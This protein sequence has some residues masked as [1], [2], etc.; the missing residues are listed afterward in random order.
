M[1]AHGGEGR[2]TESCSKSKSHMVGSVFKLFFPNYMY[3]TMHLISLHALRN[4]WVEKNNTHD[5]WDR[6]ILKQ[7]A[8][9]PDFMVVWHI[10][11]IFYGIYTKYNCWVIQ[12]NAQEA[13]LIKNVSEAWQKHFVDKTYI[14]NGLVDKTI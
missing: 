13:F 4:S 12:I 6:K 3:T 1:E 10:K 11:C 8:V 14:N 7:G 2:S 5:G 9:N